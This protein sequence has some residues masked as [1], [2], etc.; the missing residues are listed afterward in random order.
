MRTQPIQ[1]SLSFDKSDERPK[2]LPTDEPMPA[3][4]STPY[5]AWSRTIERKTEIW[6]LWQNWWRSS[7]CPHPIRST[8]AVEQFARYVETTVSQPHRIHHIFRVV[9]NWLAADGQNESQ[10]VRL[11]DQVVLAALHAHK[12]AAFANKVSIFGRREIDRLIQAAD[13]LSQ[14]DARDM[15]ALLVLY[16]TMAAPDW[17]FG[18]YKSGRFFT[19]PIRRDAVF[20]RDDGTA[21]LVFPMTDRSRLRSMTL[22]A[23][24]T[25]WL[26][27]WLESRTDGSPDMF[28]IK[29]GPMHFTA[30]RNSMDD[31]THRAGFLSRSIRGLRR[32]RV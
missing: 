11:A 13:P 7:Q 32:G 19:S 21:T 31:L 29:G 4:E 3:T 16:E 10:A 24:T 20:F 18:H 30:W 22:S 15:S 26:R 28:I 1:M 14:K 27:T 2:N 12:L 5:P 25:G 9:R 17:I 23:Q 8:N 6:Q